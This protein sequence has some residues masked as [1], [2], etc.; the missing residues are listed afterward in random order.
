[1]EKLIAVILLVAS[2]AVAQIRAENVNRVVASCTPDT[3][4]YASGDSVCGVMT[5]PSILGSQMKG[6]II[7]AQVSDTQSQNVAYDVKCKSRPFLGT[8]TDQLAFDPTDAEL[9][10]LL[11]VSIL[12]SDQY[13]YSDNAE[14]SVSGTKNYIY[15]DTP[16]ATSPTRGNIVC[17]LITR[18]TPDWD[19]SQTIALTLTV[20]TLQ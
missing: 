11:G 17:A 4:I 7:E 19:A 13:T 1:M 3:A 16:N 2:P 20:E 5:F 8:V 9:P 15:S 12:T 18:G 10:L 6:F 14:E